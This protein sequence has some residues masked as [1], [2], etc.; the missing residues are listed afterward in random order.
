MA[1]GP[2]ESRSTT[3]PEAS[4]AAAQ[5]IETP[6]DPRI[7]RQDGEALAREDLSFR[8]RSHIEPQIKS[9]LTAINLNS[10][11]GP[12]RFLADLNKYGF[13][14]LET[15][16]QA[17]RTIANTFEAFKKFC[18]ENDLKT[19][20]VLGTFSPEIDAEYR[21]P[22]KPVEGSRAF[23]HIT[24]QRPFFFDDKYDSRWPEASVELKA[25]SKNYIN[26][27]ESISQQ[28]LEHI[29]VLLGANKDLFKDKAYDS[30]QSTL[31]MIH[32]ISD[33]ELRSNADKYFDDKSKDDKH[34]NRPENDCVK[35]HTDWGLI[36]LL[37]TASNK[38]LEFWYDDKENPDG[39]NSG[40]VQL[41]SK[42]GQIIVMP[43][44]ISD[45]ISRGELRSIPHRVISQGDTDRYSL[46]YFTELKSGVDVDQLK[47]S[48][49]KP[50][51]ERVSFY[52]QEIRPHLK[53]GH[54]ITAENYLMYMIEGGNWQ[55]SDEVIAAADKL[56]LVLKS[57]D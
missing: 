4:G 31:R 1:L 51:D 37:P 38:G 5:P 17:K 21:A 55:P 42:K 53:P 23:E 41:N 54:P 39:R 28:V 49:S 16:D 40:W 48:L 8:K 7:Y 2:L 10:Q 15:D 34:K 26:L 25:L 6:P 56:G 14:I 45:I 11:G 50:G 30:D 3:R 29:A 36:T 18:T 19:K 13:A 32:C 33:K 52:E 20:K 47:E 24:G 57:K 9:Q 44:N 43:G 35:I 12:E 27:F 22:K 46:A